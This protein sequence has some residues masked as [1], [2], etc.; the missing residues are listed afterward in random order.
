MQEWLN[1][2]A[3]KAS[4]RQKRFGGSNPPLSAKSNEAR[5]CRAIDI[6]LFLCALA[7]T[8]LQT[9][10]DKDKRG[11]IKQL[12][13]QCTLCKGPRGERKGTTKFCNAKQVNPPLSAKF[14]QSR[15]FS[16]TICFVFCRYAF[17]EQEPHG[18]WREI[19][20]VLQS[21][22]SQSPYILKRKAI[23]SSQWLFY[24]MRQTSYF[25]NNISRYL[26][27]VHI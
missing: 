16:Q 4:K 20:E 23:D 5:R 8:C 22:T 24:K 1:W 15:W 6:F 21:K 7:R 13:A 25:T 3:W 12:L 10:A 17:G 26:G 18:E 19:D 11:C 9:Q 2:P 27:S 14:K